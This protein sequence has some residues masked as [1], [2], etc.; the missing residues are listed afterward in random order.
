MTLAACRPEPRDP[1]LAQ[2]LCS[3]AR[4][5]R[6][7]DAETHGR[8]LLG[9]PVSPN[10]DLFERLWGTLTEQV[11]VYFLNRASRAPIA[12]REVRYASLGAFAQVACPAS[13]ILSLTRPHWVWTAEDRDAI[14]AR[15]WAEAANVMVRA[16]FLLPNWSQRDGLVRQ[17]PGPSLTG[18]D[19][20]HALE[21]GLS[22]AESMAA[23]GQR[24]ASAAVA[25]VLHHRLMAHEPVSAL[26]F[27]YIRWA[28]R[29]IS[30]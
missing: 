21:I 9:R 11:G 2:R 14:C 18:V 19:G 17:Q 23:L 27:G 30:I 20:T 6:G 26:M 16:E 1:M 5:A 22:A 28:A 13:A 10:V 12:A 24:E 15:L 7:W 25:D 8:A 29:L 4:G 3:I